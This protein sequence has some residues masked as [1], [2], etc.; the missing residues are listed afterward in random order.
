[1]VT[2]QAI[3]LTAIIIGQLIWAASLALR[4]KGAQTKTNEA[5][6]RRDCAESNSRQHR[7]EAIRNMDNME[8]QLRCK[9]KELRATTQMLKAKTSLKAITFMTRTTGSK[10]F[11]VGHTTEA[12]TYARK[13]DRFIVVVTTTDNTQ[14]TFDYDNADIIGP[15][16]LDRDIN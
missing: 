12:L 5:I 1:M 7:A 10:R 15:I 6:Y 13:G 11:T 4:L 9:D 2:P 8:R 14:R 3:I 16:T